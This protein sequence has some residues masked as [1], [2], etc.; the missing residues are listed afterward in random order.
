MVE[1]RKSISKC[2]YHHRRNRISTASDLLSPYLSGPKLFVPSPMPTVQTV[3]VY[4]T[5]RS[6][7]NLN[8]APPSSSGYFSFA[9]FTVPSDSN[10]ILSNSGPSYIASDAEDLPFRSATQSISSQMDWCWPSRPS[11]SYIGPVQ[12]NPMISTSRNHHSD[13]QWFFQDFRVP[14]YTL[15]SFSRRIIDVVSDTTFSSGDVQTE[16][17]H[18]ITRLIIPA[19]ISKL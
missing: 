18:V 13:I 17:H 14:E 1:K 9:N 16:L 3:P 2:P 10:L 4:S 5:S 8:N 11:T 7:G 19:C 12:S 6:G 15:E